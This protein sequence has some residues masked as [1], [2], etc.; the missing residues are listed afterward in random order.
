MKSIED[1]Q[2]ETII[3][4]RPARGAWIEMRSLE[5]SHLKCK[6]RP[7]RGA[8]IEMGHRQSLKSANLSRAPQGARGLKCIDSNRI[9]EL[10]PVAPRKGR[11]D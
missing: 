5:G 10:A 2:V 6:S 4:S 9:E 7:A 1:E 11:V 3:T 8:W